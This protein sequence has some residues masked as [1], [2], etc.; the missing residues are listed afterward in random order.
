MRAIAVSMLPV[1]S[2]LLLTACASSSGPAW[3]VE[4]VYTVDATSRGSAGR[5]YAALARLY[6]AEGRHAQASE[7]WRK[8]VAAD[9]A[10][11]DLRTATGV[12]LVRLQRLDQAI[13][14]F[15]HAAA[16]QP[17]NA[18]LLNNLGYALGLEGLDDEAASVLS[19]AVALDPDHQMAR[20]NLGQVERRLAWRPTREQAAAASQK[21]TPA[22]EDVP[23]RVLAMLQ[24]DGSTAPAAITVQSLPN[25]APLARSDVPIVPPAIAAPAALPAPPA[26]S[27]EAIAA[28]PAKVNI[29]NGVG[30]TGAAA[31][32]RQLI[33]GDGV[34]VLRLQNQRPYDQARTVVQYR[35]GFQAAAMNVARRIPAGAS[36]QQVVAIDGTADLRVVLGRDRRE[37]LAACVPRGECANQSLEGTT[38]AAAEA[39]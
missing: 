33:Q 7:A 28:A 6:E 15:R 30:L 26:P 8:A 21:A 39:R 38:L 9:P 34:A 19:R 12:A 18:R 16:L 24:A 23:G 17:D 32:V 29:V 13:E 4:P 22:G 14:Q 27:P 36:T 2:A 35:A 25:V 37:A 31:R 5:G 20:V 10:D 3:K 11:V 1:A